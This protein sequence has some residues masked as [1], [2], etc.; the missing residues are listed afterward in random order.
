MYKNGVEATSYPTQTNGVG[1]RINDSITALLI[2][3]TPDTTKSFDGL[4]GLSAIIP[5]VL[6]PAQVAN[7]YNQTRHLF[8]I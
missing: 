7:I 8:G 4:I 2:G 3:N 1:A 6:T 5:S